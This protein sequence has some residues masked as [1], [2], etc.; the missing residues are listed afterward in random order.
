MA[1][2]SYILLILD[3]RLLHGAQTVHP[4]LAALPRMILIVSGLQAPLTIIACPQRREVS[5]RCPPIKALRGLSQT[6]PRQ[7]AV[8]LRLCTAPTWEEARETSWRLYA[9]MVRAMRMP[10]GSLP[11]PI[12][13]TQHL[14]A[15]THRLSAL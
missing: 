12:F 1:L 6:W 14:S 13:R 15:R 8:P 10:Q 9:W 7:K 3:A 2:I 5:N 11:P 4:F